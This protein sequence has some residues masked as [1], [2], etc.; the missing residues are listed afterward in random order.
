MRVPTEPGLSVGQRAS[1]A[2]ADAAG[3]AALAGLESPVT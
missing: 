3:R 1:S 2:A